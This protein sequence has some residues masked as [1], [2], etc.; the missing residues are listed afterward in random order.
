MLNGSKSDLKPR[1]ISNLIKYP[2]WWGSREK[3]QDIGQK[4]QVNVHLSFLDMLKK[5]SSEYLSRK[6]MV[7]NQNV[8]NSDFET[9]KKIKKNSSISNSL[10]KPVIKYLV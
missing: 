1:K 7:A 3:K 2:K 9:M 5:K 4:R 6:G 10:C 8:R